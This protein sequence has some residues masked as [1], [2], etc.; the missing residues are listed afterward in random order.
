MHTQ[1]HSKNLAQRYLPK[2]A[3]LDKILK[4][5]QKK[6]LKGTQLLVTVK[7]IQAGY[8]NIP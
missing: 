3:G 4:I 1:V 5:I 6:V 2:Q 7:E 8:L